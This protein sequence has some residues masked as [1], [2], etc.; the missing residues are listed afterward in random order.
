MSSVVH[1][2]P[3]VIR[4]ARMS[5]GIH[6]EE[7]A[8]SAHVDPEVLAK[9]ED[10]LATPT[11]RQLE[12]LADKYKRPVSVLLRSRPPD[13]PPLPMDFRRLP[14]SQRGLSAASRLAIRRARRVQ[15]I[16]RQLAQTSRSESH[17]LPSGLRQDA[18]AAARFARDAIGVSLDAQ[19]SWRSTEDA[20]RHWR[21][22]LEATGVLVLRFSMPADE[23]RGFS[24]PGVPPVIAISNQDPHP[25][26]S[27]TLFHEWCHL[28]L[29]ESGLC[30]PNELSRTLRGDDE[31]FCNAFAGAFLVPMQALLSHPQLTTLRAHDSDVGQTATAI[32]RAFSVS[33]FVV[34]RRLLAAQVVSHEDY[35]RIVSAWV[36]QPPSVRR[37]NFGPTPAV[38]AVSELGNAFVTT[39][40]TARQRGAI[41]E[42]D[43]AEYLSLGAKHLER[44]SELVAV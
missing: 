40:L 25:A 37:S 20:V 35:G 29:D 32:A 43:A 14:Q 10:D 42:T 26:Q 31:V 17:L 16:Y 41:G 23:V 44:V 11:P 38:R 2:A 27:F 34:L 30:K 19:L 22:A 9:W 7:A 4:W 24:I 12:Q 33:R 3:A 5:A 8:R 15:R 1:V 21:A 28:L 6:I 39:V 18:E 13:E 36:R